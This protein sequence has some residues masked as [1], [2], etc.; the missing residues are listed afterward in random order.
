M[1]TIFGPSEKYVGLEWKKQNTEAMA[2]NYIS[3]KSI[4]E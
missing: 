3:D 1:M 4:D 2:E